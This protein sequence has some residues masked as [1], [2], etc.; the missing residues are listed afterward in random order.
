MPRAIVNVLVATDDKIEV[1]YET[2]GSPL[3]V[4]LLLIVGF[5]AQLTLWPDG[6]C[7]MIAD[8]GYYVI[9]FD[10][11]DCG[12]ST[13]LDG[14]DVDVEGVIMAALSDQP[15]LSP[16][17]PYTLSDMAADAVGLL[18]HLGIASAHIVGQSM[19]G[20]IAQTVAIEHGAY[21]LSLTSIMSNPG[22][23]D[24][25][26]PLPEAGAVLL[27]PAATSRQAYIDSSVDW[28]IWQ[29]K[30]FANADAVRAQAAL[31]FDRS[32]YPEGSDR[33]LAAIY[34]S[35]NRSTKLASLDI[36]TLVIHG[37]DDTLLPPAGGIRTAE[38][39]DGANLLLMAD[40]GHD[41]PEPL[42]PVLVEAIVANTKR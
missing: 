11:R 2:F 32:F 15:E 9:R 20:M 6:F 21:T 17:A 39:I 22:D 14:I 41:F 33:Q 25:G 42:W 12:L 38:L 4:P 23:P 36:P 29:S 40:M 1:E 19:G 8:H 28:M 30:K 27:A 13:K 24:V 34:A 31:D 16:P 7:A 18:D 10:N 35:G 37:R 26:Q 3:D 5:G